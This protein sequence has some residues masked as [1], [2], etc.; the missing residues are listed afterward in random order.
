VHQEDGEVFPTRKVKAKATKRSAA[1][2]KA[3][4]KS[5]GKVSKRASKTSAEHYGSIHALRC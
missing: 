5:T 4:R 1:T 3:P 2:Q